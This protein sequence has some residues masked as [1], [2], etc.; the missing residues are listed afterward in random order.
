MTTTFVRRLPSTCISCLCFLAIGSA[1]V[2]QDTHYWNLQYGTRGELLGGVVVGSAVDMS[3][4]YYN[5]GSLCLVKDPSFIL[6]ASVFQVQTIRLSDSENDADAVASRTVGPAPGLIAGLLP[7]K[8][9]G[10]KWGYSFLTRQQLDFRLDARDGVLVGLDDPGDTLSIGGEVV[11][12][13]NLTENW[14]GATWSKAAGSQ[15]GVGATLYGAYRS[16]RTRIDQSI[17]AIGNNDYGAMLHNVNEVDYQTFRMLAKLGVSAEFVGSTFGVTVTTPGLEIFGTG[18]IV[19]NESL[20]GDVDADGIDDSAA[21]V[22]FGRDLPAEYHSPLSVAVG[23]SRPLGSSTVHAT[24]EWF[25]SVDE[26]TVVESPA[27]DAGPGVT[28]F[29]M[30]YVHALKS[31]WNFGFGFE[32]HFS[33]TGTAY[34][35]FIT[36]RSAREDLSQRQIVLTSWDLYQLNGGVA[37]AIK[38]I[39]FTLGGGFTWGSRPIAITPT[40][41]GVL[42]PTATPTD[43]TYRRLKVLVGFAL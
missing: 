2:A 39:D 4:T 28:S 6:T 14:G 41:Q 30:T 12:D 18:Q 9:F 26:Y 29:D 40:S 19:V 10:D 20:I 32:K 17:E 25:A 8:W 33:D 23:G 31:V 36:D 13:Q 42:P 34:A 5:P 7:I 27:P 1:A 11:L 24:V 21:E 38:G 43:M 22:S 37:L 3:A 15:F 16:Q 35:S